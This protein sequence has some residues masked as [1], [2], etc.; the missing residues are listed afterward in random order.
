MIFEV[1]LALQLDDVFFAVSPYANLLVAIHLLD[2]QLS[3]VLL[4]V[5]VLS[6]VC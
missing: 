2:P 6:C 1:I 3:I 5:G 4:P